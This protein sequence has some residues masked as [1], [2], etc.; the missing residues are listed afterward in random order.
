MPEFSFFFFTARSIM[1]L[2]PGNVL[3]DPV[4]INLHGSIDRCDLLVTT[5]NIGTIEIVRWQLN[6]GRTS[7]IRLG[8]FLHPNTHSLTA[9]H[10]VSQHMLN[11]LKSRLR[12]FQW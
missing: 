6:H 7:V 5:N 1:D 8:E 9:L 11:T 10:K 12:N 2:W 4:Q 3:E